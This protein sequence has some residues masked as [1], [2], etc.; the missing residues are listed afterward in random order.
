MDESLIEFGDASNPEHLMSLMDSL[1]HLHRVDA[2]V[3]G[4]RSRLESA[5]RYLKVQERQLSDVHGQ[6]D[7]LVA[8][9]KHVQAAIAN[10]EMEIK[11]ID[12]RL[13]KLRDELNSAVTNKQYTAI[14]NEL[15]TFKTSRNEV[16]DRVIELM[17]QIETHDGQLAEIEHLTAER[18]KVRDAASADLEQ[19]RTDV[20]ERLE[21]LELERQAAAAAVPEKVLRIFD[22]LAS[23]YD[24]EAM[25]SIEEVNRRHREYAC[26]ACNLSLPFE[27]V[28]LLMSGGD[29]VVRCS[30]C[31]RI[32]FIQE[33]L[34]GA[35]ARK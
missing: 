9:K 28:S 18:A 23:D 30:A 7:E 5:E 3:R 15:N 29:E 32:L 10:H 24:G 4:L 1:L 12:E 11:S 17:E 8:R 31:H 34:R 35:L 27:R 22:A 2:Q 16:E 33:E 6:R 20:G 19:R 13:E 21:E 26:G 14:L 25:A